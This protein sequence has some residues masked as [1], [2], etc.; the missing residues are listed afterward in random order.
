MRSRLGFCHTPIR[1]LLLPAAVALVTLQFNSF[2]LCQ[3]LS[4]TCPGAAPFVRAGD[5]SRQTVTATGGNGNPLT[6]FLATSN[7]IGATVNP[8]TGVVTYVGNW[9]NIGTTCDLVGVTDGTNS[10]YCDICW[11]PVAGVPYKVIIEAKENVAL[12]STV[13]IRLFLTRIEYLWGIGGF[14]LLIAFDN[15]MLSFLSSSPGAIY[16]SC[17]WEYFTYRLGEHDT[18]T[19]CP[20][21]L[22]HLVGIAET[23]NAA[24]HPACVWPVCGGSLPVTLANLQFNVPTNYELSCSFLPI[25]FFWTSCTDNTIKSTDN[26]H[27]SK[28]HR[29]IDYETKSN[30][31]DPMATFPTYLGSPNDCIIQTDTFY[32]DP[33]LD[34]RS[35]GIEIICSDPVNGRGDINVNEIPYEMA[36]AVMFSNYFLEGLSVFGGHIDASV[37][38]SDVNADGSTLSLPDLVH[39]IRVVLGDVP[40]RQKPNIA[41]SVLVLAQ[42]GK[43]SATGINN[44]GAV[45]MVLKGKIEIG[46]IRNDIA[47]SSAFD[48]VNTR[49][50]VTIPFDRPYDVTGFSGDLFHAD[51]VEIVSIEM[52]DIN[53]SA[54]LVRRD[55][56]EAYVLYQNYPNPFNP[57]TTISFDM[58]KA[59]PYK[60]F[61][62]NSA[63]QKITELNGSS[64]AGHRTVELNMEGNASGVYFY[65]LET[66]GFK[67]TKKALLLK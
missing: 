33:H 40:P 47:L 4:I 42:D 16:D 23:N 13:N 2:A 32:V 35:G 22:I 6:F 39:L 36:D 45:A 61:V 14:D 65:S 17:G 52:A 30:I 31:E 63:G 5:T 44:L 25:R 3:E 29:V 7:L 1:C 60:I 46:S 56:P 48:G 9:C 41:Q 51:N 58:P 67:A 37:A 57:T 8:T 49:I 19:A 50:L 26:I 38:A 64:T 55:I 54:V 12:G 27:V 24:P 62:Y 20:S 28:N 21:G 43:V 59:G 18:C 10:P 15:S 66:D 11:N 34:L 53:G